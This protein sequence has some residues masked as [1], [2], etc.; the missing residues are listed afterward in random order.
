MKSRILKLAF[1]AVLTGFFC[2]SYFYLFKREQL[3]WTY[4]CWTQATSV[5]ACYGDRHFDFSADFFGMRYQGNMRNVV[6]RH[7]FYYGAYEKPVLFL[8]R[9]IMKSA[10]SN[11]GIFLDVG[12]NTGQHSLFMSRYALEVHAFEPY[13]PVLRQFRRLVDL[14]HIKN[15][16][17]HP[18]GLG[19]ENARKPFFKPPDDMLV[20]G[21]FV[22]GFQAGNNY[23]GELE[24][25]IGDDALKKAG[26][27]SVAM[28]KMDIEGFEKPA[29]QGLGRTLA[30]NRP[31]VV[32]ELSIDPNETFTIK[33]LGELR[34]LF[35]KDYEFLLLDGNSDPNSGSYF[36]EPLAGKVRF[37]ARAQHNMVA[38]P[39]EK[40]S[41]LSRRG[42]RP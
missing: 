34:N 15:I 42:A 13:E 22:D 6:D 1:A 36:L 4:R 12:A 14:N 20:T 33:S 19:N 23:Y 11:R 39:A 9:D 2:L 8:L 21:S 17:I 10:Y 29:L 41:T 16:T 24:I 18:V 26:V 31:I 40:R 32:F 25:Q 5:R 28:I 3:Y 38:Y 30:A 35:P 7:I 27:T 37:D